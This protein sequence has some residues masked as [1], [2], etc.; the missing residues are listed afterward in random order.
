MNEHPRR[1]HAYLQHVNGR[2]I[3][4]M[5]RSELEA[6][7]SDTDANP[8]PVDIT[9]TPLGSV[10]HDGAVIAWRGQGPT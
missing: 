4:S 5:P 8:V 2:D 7:M 9:K 3:V 1:F 10:A 6:A